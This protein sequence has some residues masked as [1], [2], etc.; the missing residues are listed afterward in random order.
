[1]HLPGRT[2]NLNAVPYFA[3]LR[4]AFAQPGCAFCR[5]LA[6]SANRYLDIV[7]W[8]MVL[9]PG[10]LADDYRASD[11]LCLGHFR[12]S[13]ARSA[14]PV[15][16]RTLKERPSLQGRAVRSREGFVAA[17]ARGHLRPT[18]HKWN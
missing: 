7:L 11:G 15:Q 17:G 9:E 6:R 10:S 13:L 12:L 8:K 2:E 4:D 5:L 1:M 3:D 16:A 18:T 14:S